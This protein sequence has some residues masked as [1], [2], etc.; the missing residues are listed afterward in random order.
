[1]GGELRPQV[2]APLVRVAHV[3]EQD[4]QDLVRQPDRRDDQAFLVQVGRARGQARRLH[5]ADVRVVRARD[6]E[7]DLRAGDERDVGKMRAAGERVVDD[8]D[9]AGRGLALA[10]GGDGLRHRAE[11]YRDVLGLGDHPAVAVEER[12]RAVAALLDVRGEGGADERR[13]HLL[14]DRAERAA[15]DLELDLHVRREDQRAI[16]IPSP[17]PPGGNPAGGAVELDDRRAR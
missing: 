14:R 3:G 4:R 9:L 13:A 5:A 16:P 17:H 6:R 12:G 11:M 7:A 2:A 10:H 15:E 1:M 8:E